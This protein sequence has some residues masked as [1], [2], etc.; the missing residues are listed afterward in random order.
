MYVGRYVCM[1]ACMY[2]CLYVYV[3]VYVN[4]Y[5]YVYVFIYS[6]TDAYGQ[7]TTAGCNMLRKISSTMVKSAKGNPPAFNA[8]SLGLQQ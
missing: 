8:T 7:A 1:H 5:V 2:V 6:F 4:V 3:Y